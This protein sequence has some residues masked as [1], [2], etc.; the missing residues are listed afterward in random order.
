MVGL[1]WLSLVGQRWVSALSAAVL[2][3]NT[4]FRHFAVEGAS[5]YPESQS[6]PEGATGPGVSGIAALAPMGRSIFIAHPVRRAVWRVSC[7]AEGLRAPR[8]GAPAS[9]QMAS[10]HREG[11]YATAGL[12]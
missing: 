3:E 5:F 6:L 4:R 10:A 11:A 9:L 12:I 7:C 2:A 1:V 8:F